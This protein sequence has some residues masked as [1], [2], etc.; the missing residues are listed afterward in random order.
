MSM[1]ESTIMVEIEMGRQ[2]IR[3]L[4]RS[5]VLYGFGELKQE[6]KE[7]TVRKKIMINKSDWNL[8]SGSG[9]V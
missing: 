6:R 4:D 7:A 9:R 8:L 5:D 2:T 3:M 1:G